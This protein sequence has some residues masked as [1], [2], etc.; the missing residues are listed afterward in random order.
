VAVEGGARVLELKD[1]VG[2]E[3]PREWR[4]GRTVDVE[5]PLGVV[6]AGSV[7]CLA[8]VMGILRAL[9]ET[10]ESGGDGGEV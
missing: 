1:A 3:G 5:A 10:S 4:E 6:P 2:M 7:R 9:A 8:G